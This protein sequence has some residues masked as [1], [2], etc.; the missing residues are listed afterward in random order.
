MVF[1]VLGIIIPSFDVG[2]NAGV[3]FRAVV[4]A[5]YFPAVLSQ[6]LSN[7]TSPG[8]EL[9]RAGHTFLRSMTPLPCNHRTG[10]ATCDGLPFYL[11]YK[12]MFPVSKKL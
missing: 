7:G 11:T 5:G 10:N 8:E 12:P 1:R 6:D 4:Q 9:E 2:Q 3:A